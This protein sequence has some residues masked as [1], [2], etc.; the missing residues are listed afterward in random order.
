MDGDFCHRTHHRELRCVR[1]RDWQEHVCLSAHRVANG[2]F[3]CLTSIGRCWL[4][5]TTAPDITRQHR[6]A[7][8]LRRPVDHPDVRFPSI[9]PGLLAGRSKRGK[10]PVGP[11]NCNPV[12]DAKSRSLFANGIAWC[13][14]QRLTEPGAV[15][16]WFSQRRTAL[17]IQ[18]AKVQAPFAVNSIVL[19]NDVAVLS[20]TA[21]IAVQTLSFNGEQPTSPG[22]PSRAGRLR[23]PSGQASVSGALSE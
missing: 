5:R 7:V 18:L 23:S 22:T 19:T 16:N 14:G 9:C 11:A 13:D 6:A 20:G 21:P 8:Q 17:Q 1:P 4:R 10:W 12:I 2:S 3:T 15:K